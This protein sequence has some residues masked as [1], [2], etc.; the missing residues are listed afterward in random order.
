M[1]RPLSGR[2]RPILRV[3]NCFR[4]RS[5]AAAA[6]PIRG[7]RSPA[8]EDFITASAHASGDVAQTRAADDA[9]Q[10]TSD[11]ARTWM[12]KIWIT[13]ASRIMSAEHNEDLIRKTWT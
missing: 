1:E 13:E 7:S 9:V 4:V 10:S 8:P 5:D 11:R 2:R 12:A 3:A 6:I